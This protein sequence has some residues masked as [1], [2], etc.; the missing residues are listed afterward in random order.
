MPQPTWRVVIADDHA[1]TRDLYAEVLALMHFDVATA[2]NGA[3]ALAIC[4]AEPPHVLVADLRMPKM[5]GY[6]LLDALRR[7]P[8]TS[9]IPAIATSASLGEEARALGHGFEAFCAKPC[10][11]QRLTLSVVSLLLKHAAAAPM[12]AV[13]IGHTPVQV[14]ASSDGLWWGV[15]HG[16]QL[17]SRWTSEFS[18]RDAARVFAET[19]ELPL[20]LVPLP[21]QRPDGS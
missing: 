16:R 8:H 9:A 18:A 1:D 4:L 5:N 17:V 12:G 20:D 13:A 19:R 21:G 6:E 14:R 3:D 7:H 11:P 2:A 15:W 10:D